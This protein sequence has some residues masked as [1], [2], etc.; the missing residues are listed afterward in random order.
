MFLSEVRAFARASFSL[1]TVRI[2]FRLFSP[3]L[4]V[5]FLQFLIVRLEHTG[6][7]SDS[8]LISGPVLYRMPL[9]D[10][11]CARRLQM[12]VCTAIQK[13]SQNCKSHLL[14]SISTSAFSV[15]VYIRLVYAY[16]CIMKRDTEKD[17]RLLIHCALDF[18]YLTR[19]TIFTSL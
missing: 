19:C 16:K 10:C 9:C 5:A 7:Y 8:F 12:W 6:V 2:I 1:F 11:T 17:G 15:F 13:M 3:A 18:V 4:L 14:P